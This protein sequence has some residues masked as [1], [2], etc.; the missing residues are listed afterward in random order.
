MAPNSNDGVGL[1]GVRLTPLPGLRI[2]LSN[3]YGV[4]TFNTFYAE[5]EYLV[6]LSEDWKL[7]SAPSSRISAPSATRSCPRP[8]ASTGPRR[9][10]GRACR[11]STGTSPSRGR[12]RSP[13]PATPSRAPGELPGYLSHDRPGLRPREGV[14]GAGRR[15][16]RLQGTR[17]GPER[18][19]QLCLGMGCHQSLDAQE[20][21]QPSGVRLHR[22]LPAS[23]PGARPAGDVVPCAGGH[24]RPAGRQ[25]AR[26]P[27]PHH[28]QLG[29]GPDYS[30]RRD[31]LRVDAVGSQK[32]GE[33]PEMGTTSTNE[34]DSSV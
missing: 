30:P 16:L 29:Q 22:R 21:S 25:D 17:P 19:R 8:T 5:A 12:S 31:Q 2:D 20:G 13:A 4:N 3:Q 28:H 23:F 32:H 24:P 11:R 14:G 18:Q 6:P 33:E 15:R 1:L 9:P 34:P 7:R 10:A 26:L 27:V